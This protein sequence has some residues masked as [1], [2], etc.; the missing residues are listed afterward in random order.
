[1][2]RAVAAL[3]L[4][5]VVAA[6][7][8][9]AP[10]AP[11]VLPLGRAIGV[12][13][14]L[15]P[16]VILFGDSLHLDLTVAVDR[17]RVDPASVKLD[18][19]F[20]PFVVVRPVQVSHRDIGGVTL[21][22]F[23]LV[24]RCISYRCVPTGQANLRRLRHGRVVY[25]LRSRPAKELSVR[26]RLPAIEVITQVN[27]SLISS[28]AGLP[29]QV[30]ITP[31]V[32]H[33]VPVP[34]P[35]YRTEPAVLVGGSIAAAAVLLLASLLLARR[36]L[37]ARRPRRRLAGA[38]ASSLEQALALLAWAQRHGDETVRRKALERVAGELGENGGSELAAAAHDLAWAEPSP[39]PDEVDRFAERVRKEAGR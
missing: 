36:Y 7:A 17:R 9:A 6:P 4:A 38:P 14:P 34:K 16:T 28:Q 10:S 30:R 19:S 8:A 2:R 13:A 20:A 25:R 33:I 29:T 23:P 31:Y 22:R 18:P 32:V 5:A 35:T 12:Y 24:L 27:P 26:L 15:R 3:A 37:R 1:M 11:R 39:P 21:V